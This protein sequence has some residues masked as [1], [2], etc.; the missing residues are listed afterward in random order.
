MDKDFETI[1]RENAFVIMKFLLKLGCVYEVAEDIVQDTFVKAITYIDSFK[2]ES[3]LT[4][5]LCQI[6]RN[7]YRVLLGNDYSQI[8]SRY[9]KSESW[10][11]V[12]F[13]RA[14]LKIQEKYFNQI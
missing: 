13:Y 5:W 11:R 7:T 2:G 12:T 6:A 1:Y 8:A 10:A 3:S 4:T 14:K 9:N